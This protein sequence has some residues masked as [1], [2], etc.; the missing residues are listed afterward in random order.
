MLCRHFAQVAV[1]LPD[2]GEG[3]KEATVKEWYVKVGDQVEE[4]S[5]SNKTWYFLKPVSTR[6]SWR[7]YKSVFS[8]YCVMFPVLSVVRRF[9]RSIYRQVSGEDPF[10]CDG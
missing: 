9:V 6:I 4:V 10:H 3:T 7:Q 8:F 5:Q 2:L 1:K